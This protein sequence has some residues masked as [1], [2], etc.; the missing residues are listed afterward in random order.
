[1]SRF[2]KIWEN[3]EE[4]NLW[5]LEPDC[6]KL[7]IWCII[8]SRFSDEIS[9]MGFYKVGKGELVRQYRSI[10]NANEYYKNNKLI[11]WSTSKVA[12][13]LE[14]LKTIN[15]IDYATNRQHGTWIKI[16][17]YEKYQ[18]F[19]VN[20]E[21]SNEQK[22]DR[23]KTGLEQELNR[24]SSINKNVLRKTKNVNINYDFYFDLYSDLC[25]N[26]PSC[27]KKTDAIKKQIKSLLKNG[28]TDDDFKSMFEFANEN[29]YCIDNKKGV[30]FI[31]RKSY[32]DQWINKA[33][34][35][36]KS[37]H[38]VEAKKEKSKIEVMGESF[39]KKAD[40]CYNSSVGSYG[41]CYPSWGTY[42]HKTNEQCH[43]CKKF[44]S[45]RGK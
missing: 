45:L 28:Y 6:I 3:I 17:N 30:A 32:F 21:D 36:E 19:M 4:S 35:P 14:K 24:K 44:D 7:Y 12:S 9:D 43:Y 38:K 25:F 29:S 27:I 15:M 10:A 40:Y 39:R 13:M 11:N 1:M 2:I 20:P 31:I 41:N 23:N 8:K 18:G 33:L 22:T 16:I 34:D 26:L 42:E 37:N 5:T